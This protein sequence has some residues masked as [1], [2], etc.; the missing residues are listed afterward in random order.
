MK[1]IIKQEEPQAWRDYKRTPGVEFQA[2]PELKA[3]LLQEQGYLCC[4]CMSQIN[5]ERM[6]VEHFKPRRYA[7]LIMNYANLFAA[8]TGNFC[9]D[10]HCDTRKEDEEIVINPTDARN[11][12]EQIIGYFSNGKI[13]YPPNYYR[14]VVEILNLNN[15]VLI[16]NRRAAL[17]GAALAIKKANYNRAFITRMIQGYSEKDE[18]SK[19]KPYCNAILWL[20]RKKLSVN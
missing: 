11:N 5:S 17:L 15:S 3:S 9:S 2:I 18:N 8:C 6:K 4:Y 13:S 1:F 12:C 20:L 7:D 16:S 10:K 19:F 14:D